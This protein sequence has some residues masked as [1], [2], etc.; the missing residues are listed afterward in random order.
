[1][2]VISTQSDVLDQSA[3][4]ADASTITFPFSPVNFFSELITAVNSADAVLTA[5]SMPTSVPATVDAV[6]AA[7][8]PQNGVTEQAKL[9]NVTNNDAAQVLTL[10]NQMLMKD[11]VSM[12][13]ADINIPPSLK[14][15]IPAECFSIADQLPELSAVDPTFLKDM[16]APVAPSTPIPEQQLQAQLL[17][18]QPQTPSAPV[19]MPEIPIM[20]MQRLPP[21]PLDTSV[22]AKINSTALA[23][24]PT[25][26]PAKLPTGFPASVKSSFKPINDIQLND[27]EVSGFSR[28]PVN[29]ADDAYDLNVSKDFD[30]KQ[31][32]HVVNEKPLEAFTQLGALINSETAKH[33]VA[34]QASNIMMNV[35]HQ[36]DAITAKPLQQPAYPVKVELLPPASAAEIAQEAYTAKIKIYPPELGHV[37]AKLKSDKN[38]TELLILTENNKVKEIIESNL[39]KLKE[40]FQKSDINLTNIQVTV[41]QSGARDQN[42]S[43]N[44]NNVPFSLQPR[45]EELDHKKQS[46]EIYVQSLDSIIDTYA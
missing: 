44:R 24:S 41:S 11:Q 25:P 38:G 29:V 32:N 5:E 2:K 36:A 39:A 37:L 33:F 46:P 27:T 16:Q 31:D 22:P 13:Q 12:P 34:P 30:H 23:K 3:T 19:V 9:L 15:I 43:N 18:S 4:N 26:M 1:M 8:V 20:Q 28:Q 21:P 14:N 10:K 6:S 7:T 45:S 17:Q 40:N 42:N 35:E